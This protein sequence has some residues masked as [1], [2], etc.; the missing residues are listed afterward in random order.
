MEE[1]GGAQS[2]LDENLWRFKNKQGVL[3]AVIATHVDDLPVASSPQFLKHQHKIERKGTIA[4]R[5]GDDMN[6]RRLNLA[7]CR[8]MAF[9]ANSYCFKHAHLETVK[10]LGKMTYSAL[11]DQVDFIAG[12][13][14]MFAQRNFKEDVHSDFNTCIMTSCAGS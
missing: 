8:V 10:H 7:E 12:D 5:S 13:G 2:L 6:V 11:I 14:N 1:N 4:H 9:H 3:Q